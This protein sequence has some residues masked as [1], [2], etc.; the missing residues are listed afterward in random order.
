MKHQIIVT[1]TVGL[2]QDTT[3]LLLPFA[4]P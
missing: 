1:A 2:Q 4:I 3:F